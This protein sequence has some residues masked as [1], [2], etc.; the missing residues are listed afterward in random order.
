[1]Q[2]GMKLQK[3][4]MFS[5]MI[6]NFSA[7]DWRK[8]KLKLLVDLSGKEQLSF[9]INLELTSSLVLF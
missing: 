4:S 2:H 3:S 6:A 5:V 9:A 7:Y 1:M 8:K